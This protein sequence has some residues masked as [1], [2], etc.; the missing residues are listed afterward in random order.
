MAAALNWYQV[1]KARERVTLGC[2]HPYQ[3]YLMLRKKQG[4][5]LKTFKD[6]NCMIKCTP[7]GKERKRYHNLLDN[8]VL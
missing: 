2:C 3:V 1:P 8:N 7:V 4:Y 5:G 6:P